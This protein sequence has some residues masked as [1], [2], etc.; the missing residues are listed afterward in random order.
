MTISNFLR[1]VITNVITIRRL[2]TYVHIFYHEIVANLLP[3]FPS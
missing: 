1:I 2:I 3:N